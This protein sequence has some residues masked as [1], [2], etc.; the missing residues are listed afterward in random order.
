MIAEGTE[1]NSAWSVASRESGEEGKDQLPK[2]LRSFKGGRN[3]HI[4]RSHTEYLQRMQW[5]WKRMLG[6]NLWTGPQ[7]LAPVHLIPHAGIG[8]TDYYA[9]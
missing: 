9:C 5:S 4:S 3:T 1:R 8:K 7:K 2:A 6:S